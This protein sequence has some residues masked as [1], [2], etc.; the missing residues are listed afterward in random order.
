MPT[1]LNSPHCLT[2]NT[3]CN[4]S[5][6][7][8][9]LF[10]FLSFFYQIFMRGQWKSPTISCHIFI[11]IQH[12]MNWDVVLPD[13]HTH[14]SPEHRSIRELSTAIL[15]Y[16]F[17]SRQPLR[18]HYSPDSLGKPL[19]LAEQNCKSY[20]AV[21]LNQGIKAGIH[22][23]W[24]EISSLQMF[25]TAVQPPGL[26]LIPSQNRQSWLLTTWL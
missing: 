13:A 11:D 12:S 16:G 7:I 14:L 21:L 19:H 1:V 2:R 18:V 22:H 20:H 9:L 26:L 25:P 6:S 23:T 3:Q 4:M 24:H 15:E 5:I 8:F 17:S 10:F